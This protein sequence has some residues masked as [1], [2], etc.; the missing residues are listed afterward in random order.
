MVELVGAEEVAVVEGRQVVD[1]DLSGLVEDEEKEGKEV[2]L[3]FKHN[4]FN[5][6]LP[7]CAF[8]LFHR[9]L[10]LQVFL[11]DLD[12]VVLDSV[13][14]PLVGDLLGNQ[15]LQDEEQQLVV[16][17]AEGQVASERLDRDKQ[18]TDLIKHQIRMHQGLYF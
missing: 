5:Y 10:I 17:S 15:L 3:Q 7:R 18:N 11:C 6:S 16:V 1:V 2:L 8:Y 9:Y 14:V 4:I 12:G 13:S